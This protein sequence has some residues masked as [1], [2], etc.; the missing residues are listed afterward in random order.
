MTSP[1]QYGSLAEAIHF[2]ENVLHARTVYADAQIESIRT[3][4][5]RRQ[6]A[7]ISLSRN[8]PELIDIPH[9]VGTNGDEIDFMHAGHRLRQGRSLQLESGEAAG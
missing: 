2:L 3:G 4:R 8:E 7:P 9:A 5:I 1:P 6:R